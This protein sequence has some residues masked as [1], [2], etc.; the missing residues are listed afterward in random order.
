MRQLFL[1]VSLKEEALLA[2][3]T[4]ILP[5]ATPNIDE[6]FECID[7]NEYFIDFEKKDDDY[8]WGEFV[9]AVLMLRYLVEIN[10]VEISTGIEE[11]SPLMTNVSF[12]ERSLGFLDKPAENF[13]KRFIKP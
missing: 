6:P 2:G 5:F 12:S 7:G 1:S 3:E 10:S 4:I 9:S 11:E 8:R 13:V